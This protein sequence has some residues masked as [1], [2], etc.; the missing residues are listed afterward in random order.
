[1]ATEAVPRGQQTDMELLR[2]LGRPLRQVKK[3]HVDRA[4]AHR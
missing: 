1:M 2:G 4:G 3:V